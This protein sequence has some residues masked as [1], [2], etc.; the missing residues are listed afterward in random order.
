[1]SSVAY[2]V[3]GFLVGGA[4]CFF[5]GWMLGSRQNTMALPPDN[6]LETE[7]RQQLSQRE[8]ELVQEREK[9]SQSNTARAAADAQKN[10]AEKV[11]SEQRQLHER[12]LAETKSAQDKALADLKEVFKGL[13][14]E[15]LKQSAP[16]FLRN[17][18]LANFRKPRRAIWRSARR[19]SRDWLNRSNSN[20]KLTR[21]VCSR[22]RLRRLPRLAK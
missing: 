2:L 9:L 20:W 17:R 10:A 14:A 18:V 7:L 13:S 1:M 15:A 21:S 4:L 19:Q 3:I 5:I 11:L 8:N 16:E 6:R 22:A 12:A